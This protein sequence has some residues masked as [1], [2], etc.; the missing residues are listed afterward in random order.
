MK[1][2]L[3]KSD[4]EEFGWDDLW[5]SPKHTTSWTGV[6]NYQARNMLRDDVA[7]G[8]QL[9]FYHS[10]AK[11]PAAVGIAEIVRAGYPEKDA[12]W[13]AVDIEGKTA[14]KRPVTLDEMRDVAGLKDMVLLRRGSRLSIQPVTAAEW[15]IITGLGGVR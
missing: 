9:L 4:P 6:R 2:W 11:P 5:K 13:V 7:V 8:D 1:Y 3:F 12:T 10:S 15:R 14:F